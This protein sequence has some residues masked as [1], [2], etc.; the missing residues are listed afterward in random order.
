[1]PVGRGGF[2]FDPN[3]PYFASCLLEKSHQSQLRSSS[4]SGKGKCLLRT[5]GPQGGT[6]PLGPGF[7]SS[8]L[9]SPGQSL[10]QVPQILRK[11]PK[12]TGSK[13]GSLPSWGL[14]WNAEQSFPSPLVASGLFADV[15]RFEHNAASNPVG[16]RW[17]RSIKDPKNKAFLTT[18]ANWLFSALTILD[19][20]ARSLT[21]QTFLTT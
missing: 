3:R 8:L 6:V 2:L 20:S 5:L 7:S 13:P 10:T 21:L 12:P 15:L 9:F 18:K 4:S 16:R 1:M 11:Q 19:L 17:P 14:S